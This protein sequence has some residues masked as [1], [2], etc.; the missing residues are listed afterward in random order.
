[1]L[2]VVPAVALAGPQIT[3]YPIS[4]KPVFALNLVKTMPGQLVVTGWDREFFHAVGRDGGQRWDEHWLKVPHEA[5]DKHACCAVGEGLGGLVLGSDPTVLSG[6]PR[7][8]LPVWYGGPVWTEGRL[9]GGSGRAEWGSRVTSLAY[10]G[11]L[12]MSL[13]AFGGVGVYEGDRPQ[14]WGSTDSGRTW[15]VLM[16][17]PRALGKAV[18][19][20]TTPEYIVWGTFGEF[21][22]RLSPDGERRL[23]RP[24]SA[25][26]VVSLCA[27]N[28]FEVT[29][30]HA[31]PGPQGRNLGIY[32]S[33][34]SGADW[35][36]LGNLARIPDAFDFLGKYVGV[37]AFR[38]TH[39]TEHT[40]LF[41]TRDGCQ[42]WKQ[43]DLQGAEVNGIR[44]VNTA[45]IYLLAKSRSSY[46][47]FWVKW[48]PEW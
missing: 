3:V 23:V 42:T 36:R 40:R 18:A 26:R 39:P 34:N 1:L 48:T 6:T 29:V 30:A 4:S 2:G 20:A 21:L 9:L 12:G 47:L 22:V 31:E 15:Q 25:H 24:A 7:Y 35:T 28:A 45:E 14:V 8:F 38:E 43:W 19:H 13:Y 5:G 17:E 37:A 10:A 11:K 16:D 33:N 44:I 27:P 46:R 32:Y 41:Y